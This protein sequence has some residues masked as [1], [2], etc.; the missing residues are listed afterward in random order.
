M[1]SERRF[2]DGLTKTRT[3]TQ[4]A[5]TRLALL[6]AN[7]HGELALV[8]KLSAGPGELSD[9]QLRGLAA[10]RAKLQELR[11]TLYAFL[12]QFDLG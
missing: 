6:N 5:W 9:A 10:N 3:Y 8:K 7:V 2:A 4:T 11:S 12:H 1:N